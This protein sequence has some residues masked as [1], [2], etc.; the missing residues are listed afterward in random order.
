[1]NDLEPLMFTCSECGNTFEPDPRTM[2]ETELSTTPPPE[3]SEE[4]IRQAVKD[5]EEACLLG[6]CPDDALELS[7]AQHEALERGETVIAGAVCVCL[8]CQGEG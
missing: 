6:Q 8:E 5:H 2:L 4:D 3:W 1:M 7:Q